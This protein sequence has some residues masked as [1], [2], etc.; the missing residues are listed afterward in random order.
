[1]IEEDA[2]STRPVS[3]ALEVPANTLD[4]QQPHT[5]EELQQRLLVL[6]SILNI[7]NLKQSFR[8]RADEMA[9]ALNRFKERRAKMASD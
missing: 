3:S 8:S 7:M 5:P 9:G 2:M 6:N 4:V 1:L